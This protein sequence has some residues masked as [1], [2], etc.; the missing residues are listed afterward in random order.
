[1]SHN[2]HLIWL[3]NSRTKPGVDEDP[4][5]HT[6]TH[7]HHLSKVK[8]LKTTSNCKGRGSTLECHYTCADGASLDSAILE[9]TF[10]SLPLALFSLKY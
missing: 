1:M 3:E 9:F 2:L 4:L 10:N 5:T 6:H 7:A 8:I